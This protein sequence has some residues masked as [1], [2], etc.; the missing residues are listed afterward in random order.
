MVGIRIPNT[1][2]RLR[3]E[4]ETMAVRH[5]ETGAV[6]AVHELDQRSY[7]FV[8]SH[9]NPLWQC[10]FAT[11]DDDHTE[12][13]VED[14][15][16]AAQWAN[17]FV[18]RLR[19]GLHGEVERKST[20][21]E[22][23]GGGTRSLADALQALAVADRKGSETPTG[24]VASPPTPLKSRARVTERRLFDEDNLHRVAQH[25]RLRASSTGPRRTQSARPVHHRSSKSTM[26]PEQPT[27]VGTS[28]VRT[29]IMSRGY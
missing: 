17:A 29:K 16:H 19:A 5:R 14:G 12:S 28:R 15:L 2:G 18:S 8:H 27:T 24:G 4:T 6:A 9:E 25:G 1:R 13:C 7:L 21:H 3:D 22:Q 11:G 10:S 23:S 26:A 20:W